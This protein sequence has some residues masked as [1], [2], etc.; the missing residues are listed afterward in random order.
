MTVTALKAR[1]TLGAARSQSRVYGAMPWSDRFEAS[2]RIPKGAQY[3]ARAYCSRAGSRSYKIYLPASQPTRPKGLILMLHG[4]QQTPDY[5]ALGTHMNALSEKNGLA[6]A[7]PAQTGA[8]NA[9]SCW[10][11]FR[12]GDQMPG[13]GEPAI[14]ASLRRKLM[15]EFGLGRDAVERPRASGRRTDTAQACASFGSRAPDPPPEPA[16]RSPRGPIGCQAASPSARPRSACRSISSTSI[17]CWIIAVDAGVDPRTGAR[18]SRISTRL[19]ARV[20]VSA[21]RAPLMPAPTTITSN[22]PLPGYACTLTEV[23]RV[24]SH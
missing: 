24:F 18:R 7:Y 21:R 8:D 20:R 11:W 6:L 13:A 12:P 23:P 3:L 2:P 19:P 10:N 17:S 4:C 15:K 9:A 16:V 14:L 5:F 22:R 1:G